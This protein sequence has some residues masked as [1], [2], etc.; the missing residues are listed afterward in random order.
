MSGPFVKRTQDSLGKVIKKPPLTEKLLSKPPF[1]YL[2]DIFTEVIRSTGFLKGLYTEFEMKSDNVKDKDAKIVFLQKAIDVVMMVSGDPLSVKPARVVAGHE[3]E[4]TNELLQIMAKCCLNKLSSD[5][6]V[7]KVLA[8]EK[9]DL[10]AKALP[11]SKSQGKEN[12]EKKDDE[13]KR[14]KDKEQEERNENGIKHTSGD[15]KE[16]EQSKEQGKPMDKERD[17]HKDGDRRERGKEHERD[18]TRTKERDQENH[19][20]RGDGEKVEKDKNRDGEKVEKDKIRGDGEKDKERSKERDRNKDRVREKRQR[21]KEREHSK[22]QGRDQE[23]DREQDKMDRRPKVAADEKS[24]KQLPEVMKKDIKIDVDQ[25]AE[26]PVRI[27]RPSSA[28]GQRRKPK[29]GVEE[30]ER[31]SNTSVSQQEMLAQKPEKETIINK[32]DESDL[33][34]DL[35]AAHTS[36]EKK[37]AAEVNGEIPD[38]LSPQVAQRRI[39]RPGSARPAPPRIKKQES[40]DSPSERIG[41]AKPVSNVIVDKGKNVEEEEDDDEQFVV[42]EAVSQLPDMPEM[43]PATAVE[44]H[45]REDHGVLVRKILETKKDYESSKSA[46][47]PKDQEKAIISETAKKKERELVAKEIEKLRMA[48]Q[49]LCRSALPLGKIMDYIQEDMDSMQNELSMWRRENKKHAESLLREQSI[50][51]TAVE[52]LKTELAELEQLIKDQQD[53]NCAVKANILKNEDK[54]QKMISSINFSSRT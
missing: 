46:T 22:D 24:H 47:K 40:P 29:S 16:K 41:S 3:P 43:E 28:K 11:S 30:E 49:N 33:E 2:H 17:R 50:T 9:T 23:A 51:D 12:R 32:L 44:L 35:E 26:S 48:I 27:P 39:P 13:R 4:K 42:E 10:K 8:G 52:P 54:I 21:D 53:K 36:I 37:N 5:D 25:E 38:E 45:G 19:K 14:Q 1:R 7:R 31:E 18:R 15:K 6:S 34:G 20:N